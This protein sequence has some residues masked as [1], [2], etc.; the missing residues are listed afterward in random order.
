[1]TPRTCHLWLTTQTRPLRLNTR[2]PPLWIKAQTRPRALAT[3][4][5]DCKTGVFVKNW[6]RDCPPTVDLLPIKYPKGIHSLHGKHTKQTRH[7]RSLSKH[8]YHFCRSSSPPPPNRVKSCFKTLTFTFWNIDFILNQ[9]G[10]VCMY[11][12][13]PVMSARG[14]ILLG[15][16]HPSEWFRHVHFVYN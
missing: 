2:T 1:M 13:P 15:S 5:Q 8:S 12:F 4:I 6:S 11:W 14:S 9:K 16:D 7:Y 10:S 3:R